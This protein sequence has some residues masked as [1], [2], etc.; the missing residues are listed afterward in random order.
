MLH[1][2]SREKVNHMAKGSK[3]LSRPSKPTDMPISGWQSIARSHLTSAEI[4]A[5]HMPPQ[6]HEALYLAGFA[7][8]VALKG[9]TLQEG[10]AIE[11]THD[12]EEL[13]VRSQILREAKRTT[14]PTSA[15][16]ALGLPAGTTYWDLFDIVLSAWFNELR[17]SVG[18]ATPRAAV[19]FVSTV[20]ELEGWLWTA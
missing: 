20:K 4:L 10:I 6:P 2:D 7:L 12:L 9:K 16:T 3:P 8:E 19:D 1:I 17:Y 13:L 5:N 18:S 11:P 14:I 15:E